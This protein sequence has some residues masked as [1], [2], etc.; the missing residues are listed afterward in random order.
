M[1]ADTYMKGVSDEQ[2]E[3]LKELHKKV[4]PQW[5]TQHTWVIDYV[6]GPEK[7]DQVIADFRA[8]LARRGQE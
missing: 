8:E 6:D 5:Q 7:A 4:N 3:T 2:W 1:A